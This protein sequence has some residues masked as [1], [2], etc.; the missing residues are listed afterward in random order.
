MA[1]MR[2]EIIE[3]TASA[4]RL[5]RSY[6]AR[7][8]SFGELLEDI[9]KL[10]AVPKCVLEKRRA[11]MRVHNRLI[12]ASGAR[13]PDPIEVY[14]F[15]K[16]LSALLDWLATSTDVGTAGTK[17]KPPPRQNSCRPDRI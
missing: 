5:L 4:E 14:V 8:N 15:S 7:G 10:Y 11:A 1:S 16:G 6:G 13:A 3:E 17:I 2:D 12:R 9:A